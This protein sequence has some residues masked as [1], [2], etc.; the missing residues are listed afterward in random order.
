MTTPETNNKDLTMTGTTAPAK[1]SI[2]KTIDA[3]AKKLIAAEKALQANASRLKDL[4]TY[5]AAHDPA[6]SVKVVREFAKQVGAL[7]ALMSVMTLKSAV[8]S[9]LMMMARGR[10]DEVVKIAQWFYQ[11]EPAEDAHW[12]KFEGA[13]LAKLYDMALTGV[14]VG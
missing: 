1:P 14:S 6:K 7:R 5:A 11:N 12:M 9:G 2:E 13:P 3:H 8:Y 4:E 10:S